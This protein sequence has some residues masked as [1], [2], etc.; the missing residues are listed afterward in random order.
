MKRKK[1]II[2]IV[3]LIAVLLIVKEIIDYF[4]Y[5][6]VGLPLPVFGIYNHDTKNHS[7]NVQIFDSNNKSLFDK[8][9]ELGDSRSEAYTVQYPE[10]GKWKDVHEKDRL[11]PKG[12]YTFI[13]TMDNN[14]SK[15]QQIEMD[16]WRLASIRIENNGNI[17][18]GSMTS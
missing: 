8:I 2:G 16:T 10:N 18:I 15:T 7:V 1:L 14:I 5:F 12:T 17:D 6:M 4:P 3:V 13:V 9:Y 11:F